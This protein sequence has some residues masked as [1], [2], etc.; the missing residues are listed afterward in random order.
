M[1]CSRGETGQVLQKLRYNIYQ[2]VMREGL[3]R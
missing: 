1:A 2:R 3:M